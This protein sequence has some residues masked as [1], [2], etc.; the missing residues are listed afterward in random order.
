MHRCMKIQ[1][2]CRSHVLW[3]CLRL[4]RGVA[5]GGVP[6]SAVRG[7]CGPRGGREAPPSCQLFGATP[8]R[9]VPSRLLFPGSVPRH[10]CVLV[11]RQ[12]LPSPEGLWALAPALS[13]FGG[14]VLGE[15]IRWS[16]QHHGALAFIVIFHHSRAFWQEEKLWISPE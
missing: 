10:G 4:R 2:E 8:Q 6:G 14:A 15:L 16:W 7:V 3:L 5:A 1:Q 12:C 13:V 9:L 11:G